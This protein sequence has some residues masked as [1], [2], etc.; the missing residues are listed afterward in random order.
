MI[1]REIDDEKSDGSVMVEADWSC[2]ICH[3][4]IHDYEDGFVYPEEE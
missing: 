2:P 4:I 1:Y 3:T